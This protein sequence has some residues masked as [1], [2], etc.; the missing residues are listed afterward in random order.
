MSLRS[1]KL[2]FDKVFKEFKA[3]IEKMFNFS[4]VDRVSGVKMYQYPLCEQILVYDMCTA[5]PRPYTDKLF[6]SLADFLT[7][8]TIQIRE[9]ILEHN[10]IVN[11]YYREWKRYRLAAEYSSDVCDYLNKRLTNE[12]KSHNIV[13]TRRE[14]VGGGK[15]KPQTFQALAYLIWKEQILYSIKKN[16]G[17]RLMYQIFQ[18]IQR[19][20]DG[21]EI[22]PDILTEVIA[23]LEE[24]Q[25]PYLKHTRQYYEREAAEVISS[26]SISD[27]MKKASHRL[28]EEAVRSDK[29]CHESSLASVSV[30]KECEKQYI[31]VHQSRIHNEFESMISKEQYEDCTLA[32]KILSRNLPEGLTHLL[33]IYE[34]FITNIGKEMIAKMGNTIT[35]DPREYLE[36]LMELHTKYMS[37][38][39][40]VFNNDPAFVASVDKAFRTIV[41]DK[42]TNPVAHSPEIMA[43]YCDVLL[44]RNNKGGLNESEIDEKL[45]R[46]IACGVEY[47]NK[48]QRM[49]TDITISTDINNNFVDHIKKESINIGVDFSILVLTTGA[50]PLTQTVGT[51]FQL[52]IELEK[53]ITHFSKFYSRKHEGRRLTWL[54]HLS[55]ADVKLSYLDKRYEF[56]VS[57]HQLGVLLLYNNNDVYTFKEISEN[58]GLNEQELKRIMKPMIDLLVFI[59]SPPGN[60]Q[61]ETKIRLNMEFTNKRNKIKIGTSLQT[62]TPQENDATRRSAAIVRVMKSRKTL[63]HVQLVNEV[64]DQAKNRFTPN[65]PMIKKCIEQLL[66]KQYL[67]RTPG[68]KDKYVYVA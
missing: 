65:V 30:I 56:S 8:H 53:N 1:K 29:Y 50:W 28:E 32:Y 36:E 12:L 54:W 13:A 27:Y 45:N 44:K 62:E 43:R 19:N 15:Y 22:V 14:N 25:K 20:R 68:T 48:L 58:I 34:L 40:K 10:D 67:Q 41:N 61:E 63:S 18:L 5:S 42:T 52:P 46:M 31:T 4:G 21:K 59:I 9:S 66:E 26:S 37:F 49:F 17:D 23:S 33:E 7:Q 2:N 38:C 55:K 11:E 3:D 47:T 6:N 35:K 64:V 60:L 57:L 24:F 39:Q 16:H 51:E